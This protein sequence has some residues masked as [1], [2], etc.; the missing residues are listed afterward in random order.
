MAVPPTRPW[1]RFHLSTV[2]VAILMTGGFIG[3]NF[4]VEHPPFTGWDRF[5]ESLSTGFLASNT[6]VGFPFSIY[7]IRVWRDP[8]SI[9]G[10]IQVLGIILNL[11]VLVFSIFVVKVLVNWLIQRKE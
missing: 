11:M 2:V 3:L 1:F 9:Q 5:D 4:N 10:G 6:T 8:H 7:D